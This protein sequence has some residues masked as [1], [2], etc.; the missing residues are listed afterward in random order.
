VGFG[1]WSRFRDSGTEFQQKA[2]ADLR[3]AAKGHS[4]GTHKYTSKTNS[5]QHLGEKETGSKWRGRQGGE[6][7]WGE[8]QSEKKTHTAHPTQWP[9]ISPTSAES[10]TLIN[11]QQKAKRK[12][13][14]VCRCHSSL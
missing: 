6:K 11:S 13:L 8:R 7:G 5:Q 14:I 4:L 12:C 10:E 3:P 1:S 2:R 9:R